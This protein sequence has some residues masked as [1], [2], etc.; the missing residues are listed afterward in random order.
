VIVNQFIEASFL[1]YLFLFNCSGG[2]QHSLLEL[3]FAFSKQGGYDIKLQY[4]DG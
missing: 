2:E 3:N 4:F 1:D